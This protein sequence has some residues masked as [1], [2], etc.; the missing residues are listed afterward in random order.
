MGFNSTATNSTVVSNST[1]TTTIY[2]S[3]GDSVVE[4]AD[5][6]ITEEFWGQFELEKCVVEKVGG[7]RIERLTAK[8]N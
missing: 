2:D 7:R 5:E 3:D 6:S 1:L 4:V 8:F